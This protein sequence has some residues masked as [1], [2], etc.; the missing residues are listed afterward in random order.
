MAR[1]V[2]S[3]GLLVLLAT[4]S[5]AQNP[6]NDQTRV[7]G[8]SGAGVVEAVSHALSESC[9][10]P[11]DHR[12]LRRLARVASNDGLDP[13]TYRL[14]FDGGIW[15][16]SQQDFQLTQSTSMLNRYYADIKTTFNIDWAL[17]RWV[18]LRKPLY[19]GIAQYLTL[20]RL[21]VNAGQL[22][23][24]NGEFVRSREDQG[25]FYQNII[26]VAG[27]AYTFFQKTQG[28][29]FAC[30]TD[31]LDMAFLV[32]SSSSVSPD[33][34]TRAKN[35]ANKVVSSSN[36]NPNGAR[37]SFLTF[38]SGIRPAF[39]FNKYSDPNQVSAAINSVSQDFG[40]T[41]THLALGYAADTLFTSQAGS[42]FDSAKIAI[43]LTDGASSD[44]LL[45]ERNADKLR[46]EGVTVFVIGVGNSTVPSELNK[47]ATQPSCTHVQTLQGYSDLDT[48]Q[49]EIR[50]VACQTSVQLGPV[51]PN[52]NIHT[53]YQCGRTNTFTIATSFETTITIK[54]RDGFVQIFG[55][56]SFSSP[57][58]SINDMSAIASSTRVA[59]IYI[60][61]TTAPLYLTIVSDP[62]QASQCGTNFD[63]DIEFGDHLQRIGERV[64]VDFGRVRQCTTLD[65]LRAL[66]KVQQVVPPMTLNPN[67][68]RGGVGYYNYLDFYH[69][70]Y[71]DALGHAWIITCNTNQYYL[72]TAR[73]CV[74]GTPQ[75]T[76]RPTP[77]PTPYVPPVTPRPTTHRPITPRPT[78]A[79]VY[80]PAPTAALV[81][82]ATGGV[83]GVCTSD[84]WN[85][86]L[87]FFPYA[88]NETLYIMCT[89]YVG[90]CR[91]K[92]CA[93][94]H[95][96]NQNH[97]ACVY[98]D[99]VLDYTRNI[100]QTSPDP[101]FNLCAKVGVTDKDILY[102][103]YPNDP[104]KFFHCD[105]FGQEF[106][107]SCPKDNV[108]NQALMTCVPGAPMVG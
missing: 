65:L 46:K 17:V 98:T 34:F 96:W 11:N 63:L 25:K 49:A 87:R 20:I 94:F 18:D 88:G 6:T 7:S 91:I 31:K 21:A 107:Q 73:D 81:T 43:L 48:L 93:D 47:W 68:C 66:Y 32:D 103:P 92:Q 75:V 102:H 42:R 60:R 76:Q 40:N 16:I 29:A 2:I 67:P 39:D 100:Y 79:P 64:C 80:T 36:V 84:N 23:V 8:A 72:D 41:D 12:F 97:L 62:L 4:V 99:L 44:A 70:V 14:G 30:G 19:S 59:Q 27:G 35:F 77:A 26:G 106:I 10:F 37:I 74:V 13:N 22:S 54:P 85:R 38:S 51:S 45:A 69:F 56:Y 95:K 90:V 101:S 104:T 53:V 15:Q 1:G 83:C 58:A 108:W 61:N 24:V 57:S 78:Q 9:I 3:L 105:E 86:N 55:S 50:Q 28:L 82:V 33:D 5:T 71:C 89:E 52:H